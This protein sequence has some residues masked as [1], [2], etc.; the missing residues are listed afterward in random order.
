MF[1]GVA[2]EQVSGL[3]QRVLM[4]GAGVVV[5]KGWVSEA[6]AAQIVGGLVAF[7]G[8]LW[9]IKVNTPTALTTSVKNLDGVKGV[10][11]ENNPQ[12]LALAQAIPGPQVVP[13][14]TSDAKALVN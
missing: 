14:G 4:F 11:T 2:W 13:A 6:A 3:V 1:K 10:I 9:G 12:G 5:A 7:I 8:V